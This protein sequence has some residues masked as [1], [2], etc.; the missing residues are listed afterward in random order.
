MAMFLFDFLGQEKNKSVYYKAILKN[1]SKK[2]T[3][4]NPEKK[5]HQR[6]LFHYDHS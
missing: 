6:V 1:L 2:I 3:E 5:K 4:T